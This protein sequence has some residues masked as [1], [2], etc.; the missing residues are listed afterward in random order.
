MLRTRYRCD[1]LLIRFPFDLIRIPRNNKSISGYRWT[2]KKNHFCISNIYIYITSWI[3]YEFPFNPL[4]WRPALFNLTIYLANIR[5]RFL[6]RRGTNHHGL[7]SISVFLSSL[8]I[9]IYILSWGSAHFLRAKH[10]AAQGSCL[11]YN[12]T[13]KHDLLNLC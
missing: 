2:A 6:L 4:A 8:R 11:G 5:Y 12:L 10:L 3:I 1:Y 7:L 13:L 9:Y